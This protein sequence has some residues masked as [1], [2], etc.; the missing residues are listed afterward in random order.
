SG[1]PLPNSRPKELWPVLK[2]AAPKIFGVNFFT[3]ALKYCGAFKQEFG[4]N[5]DGFTN[6]KEFKARVTK[7]FMLRMKKNVLNLPPKQEG[8]LTVG[9][10]IPPVVSNVEKKILAHYSPEDLVEGEI[11]KLTGKAALHL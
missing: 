11:T 4:W 7:S 1:T 5:F 8:L 10:G 2:H 6:R 3:F 9:E